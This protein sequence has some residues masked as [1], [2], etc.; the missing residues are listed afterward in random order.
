[1]SNLPVEPIECSYNNFRF[2]LETETV[3]LAV[4]PEPDTSNRTRQYC[5]IAITL[6]STLGQ[7]NQA[8]GKTTDDDMEAIRILLTTQGGALV[9]KGVGFG[10][11]SVN[12]DPDG[13]RD[14]KWGPIPRM[15]QWKPLGQRA[16]EIIWLVE[17]MVPLC[18]EATYQYALMEWAWS[19][20]VTVDRSGY[21][22][23]TYAGH[24]SIPQTRRTVSDRTLSDSADGYLEQIS[25]PLLPGYRRIRGPWSLSTDKCRGDFSF[26]DE[27]MPA[28]MPPPGCIDVQMSH[29]LHTDSLYSLKWVGSLR[30]TYEVS[31]DHAKEIALEHFLAVVE[32]RIRRSHNL[33]FRTLLGENKRTVVIHKAVDISE[34]EIYGRRC[35]SFAWQYLFMCS[36]ED[37][38]GHSGLWRPITKGDWSAWAQSLR[39]TAFAV[40]GASGLKFSPDG[41]VILDLCVAGDSAFRQPAGGRV[42]RRAAVRGGRIQNAL[43][44]P[45][46]SY[47]LH[48]NFVRVCPT[49][50][51]HVIKPLPSSS[52]PLSTGGYSLSTRPVQRGTGIKSGDAP[53]S[54]GPPARRV[55]TLSVVPQSRAKDAEAQVSNTS[56]WVVYLEGWAERAGYPVGPP[57]LRSFA[58]TRAVPQNRRGDGFLYGVVANWFGLDIHRCEWR[59]R[60]VLDGQ[61]RGTFQTMENFMLGG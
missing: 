5:R 43:P 48:A 29:S 55:G 10:D 49:D 22:T 41:D 52:L 40:R 19:L 23:R 18:E 14:V 39:G 61:P 15:L 4:H 37:I 17:T 38:V 59:L 6:K 21:S 27:E 51:V 36:L 12:V 34:A 60:Y 2:P 13:M 45:D 11:L 31:K 24:I 57:E 42:G 54:S 47:L 33:P 58:G 9:Y 3:S 28:N 25:P 1:M 35:G 32:D 46:T 50:H 16:C 44:D 56:Q 20:T 30:G 26:V 7:S 8:E 53:S